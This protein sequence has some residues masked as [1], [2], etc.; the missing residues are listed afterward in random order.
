MLRSDGI[1]YCLF[2]RVIVQRLYCWSLLYDVFQLPVL[3]SVSLA[4]LMI[5]AVNY[6]GIRKTGIPLPFQITVR[7]Y[8]TL[9]RV[10]QFGTM[11]AFQHISPDKKL[12]GSGEPG[13]PRKSARWGARVKQASI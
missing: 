8:L 4:G 1:H 13:A 3:H 12:T 2:Q 6:T 7:K 9:T 5:S 11:Y 10:V